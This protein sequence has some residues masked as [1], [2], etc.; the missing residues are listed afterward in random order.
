MRNDDDSDD[1]DQE[2]SSTLDGVV[3]ITLLFSCCLVP[4]G[5]TALAFVSTWM[6]SLPAFGAYRP[7]LA[8]IALICGVIAWRR[9]YRP[10]TACASEKACAVPRPGFGAKV[11]FWVVAFSM[12]H[13]LGL[14]YFEKYL[15]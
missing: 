7:W 8:A 6:S 9:I 1:H 14:P 3:L 13:V 10:R 2:S 4:L 12:W 5:L 11:I 15:Y